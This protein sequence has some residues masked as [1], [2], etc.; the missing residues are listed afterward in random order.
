MSPQFEKREQERKAI[1]DFV[2]DRTDGPE[3]L[4]LPSLVRLN[5]K[6]LEWLAA[7]VANC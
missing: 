3:D 5:V 6:D 7:A 4:E 1:T 2:I